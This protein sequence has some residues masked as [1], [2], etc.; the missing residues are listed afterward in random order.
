MSSGPPVSALDAT[1]LWMEVTGVPPE[2][3]FGSTANIS[4]P[5]KLS[6]AE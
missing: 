1:R 4:E 5:L 3:E 6:A 2:S